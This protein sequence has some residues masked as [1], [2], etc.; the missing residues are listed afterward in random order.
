MVLFARQKHYMQHLRNIST[1]RRATDQNKN[2]E[3]WQR[4]GKR[5]V[6]LC[7]CCYHFSALQDNE[8]RASLPSPS[9]VAYLPVT[10]SEQFY[11]TGEILVVTVRCYLVIC[12]RPR[13]KK[14]NGRGEDGTG[15]WI[16]NEDKSVPGI[17]GGVAQRAE[18]PESS[19]EARVASLEQQITLPGHTIRRTIQVPN[20]NQSVPG[21]RDGRARSEKHRVSVC[22]YVCVYETRIYLLGT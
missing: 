1:C 8:R 2:H 6:P 12:Q 16:K 14:D 19:A 7:I 17:A 22:V 10:R 3:H 9:P 4:R 13:E 21:G 11:S 15:R 18:T 20:R 5:N